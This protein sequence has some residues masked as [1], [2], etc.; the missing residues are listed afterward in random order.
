MRARSNIRLNFKIATLMCK[1]GQITWKPNSDDSLAVTSP[2]HHKNNSTYDGNSRIS[3]KTALYSQVTIG[4]VHRK[5]LSVVTPS[6]RTIRDKHSSS[7]MRTKSF[8]MANPNPQP[9]G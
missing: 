9:I 5:D 1:N 6:Y 4:S 3:N 2:G 7:D 8:H